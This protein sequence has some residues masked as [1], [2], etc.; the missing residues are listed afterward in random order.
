MDFLPTIILES[1]PALNQYIRK[2]LLIDN[3]ISHNLMGSHQLT[4][5]IIQPHLTQKS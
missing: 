3:H 1:N 2:A 5:Q 4:Q